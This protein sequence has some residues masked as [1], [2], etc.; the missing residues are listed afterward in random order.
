MTGQ[1]LAEAK[2]CAD[3]V[4]SR[5]RRGDALSLVQFDH[6]VQRLWPAVP[7]GDGTPQ[8]AAIAGITAGGNTTCTAAGSTARTACAMCRAAA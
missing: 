1:P 4:L 3:Y 6:R 8:L 2:R 5:L 7:V